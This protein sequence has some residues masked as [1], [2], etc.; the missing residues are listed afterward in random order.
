MVCH[1]T[2]TGGS[3]LLEGELDGLPEGS[4]VN[5]GTL[6]LPVEKSLTLAL[7]PFA[8]VPRVATISLNSKPDPP[9]NS[10]E[11]SFNG[12]NVEAPSAPDNSLIVES[13]CLDEDH[14]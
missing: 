7:L 8:G 3:T 1:T 4:T 6:P 14:S 9:T 11:A 5:L 12:L 13:P 10:A 2:V